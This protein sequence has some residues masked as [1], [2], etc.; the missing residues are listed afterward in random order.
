MLKKTAQP[1]HH[2]P[3]RRPRRRCP[4]PPLPIVNGR[5]QVGVGDQGPPSTTSPCWCRDASAGALSTGTT[6]TRRHHLRTTT[7]LWRT[8]LLAS[9]MLYHVEAN[10]TRFWFW[11]CKAA[12]SFT[13]QIHTHLYFHTLDD[14]NNVEL[15]A[16]R[17]RHSDLACR[18]Q[19]FQQAGYFLHVGAFRMLL[20]TQPAFQAGVQLPQWN[21]LDLIASLYH[22][23]C[24]IALE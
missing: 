12:V 1:R 20:A 11:C 3:S 13:I 22:R 5:D 2:H 19:L 9:P 23:V 7:R 4:I 17:G 16:L 18:L 14:H 24:H 10:T 21:P 6:G 15:L 8:S